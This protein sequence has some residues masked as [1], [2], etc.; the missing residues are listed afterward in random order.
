[1]AADCC[2]PNGNVMTLT[3]SGGS[4]VGQPSNQAAVALAHYRRVRREI[5]AVVESLPAVLKTKP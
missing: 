4:Q 3:G 5:R 2:S 1:M